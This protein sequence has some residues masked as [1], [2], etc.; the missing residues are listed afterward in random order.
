MIA[1][2]PPAQVR[3]SATVP[4]SDWTVARTSP[5]TVKAQMQSLSI[6][7]IQKTANTSY[8]VEGTLSGEIYLTGTMDNPAGTGH[9]NLASAVVYGEPLSVVRADFK[10][11][12]QLITVDGEARSTAGALTARVSYNP[13]SKAYET[14]GEAKNLDL[15]QLPWFGAKAQEIAGKLS[16]TFGGKGTVDDPQAD[17]QVESSSL[18]VRGEN[19]RNFKAQGNVRN[20]RGELTV[21]SQ[22]ENTD[23]RASGHIDLKEPY[24]AEAAIDTGVV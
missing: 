9:L 19:L 11:E 5:L 10:A 4:F 24:N 2:N 23:V 3:A 22:V 18:L 6:A 8:P 15:A 21:A 12:S 20:Q 14:Q 16:V 7:A 13:H 17:F 1:T